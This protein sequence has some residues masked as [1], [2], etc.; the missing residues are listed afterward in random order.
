MSLP[1]LTSIGKLIID[2]GAFGVDIGAAAGNAAATGKSVTD[3][4]TGASE[5]S[6]FFG[7][8]L[9][10]I[11]IIVLGLLLITAGLFSFDKTRELVVTG[12]KTAA[13]V[14]AA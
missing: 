4:I 3:A 11:V 8:T 1:D 2:P 13:K 6:S 14:A 9:T 12:A 7:I 5:S 10:N